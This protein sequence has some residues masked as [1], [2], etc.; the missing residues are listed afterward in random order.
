MNRKSRRLTVARP[1]VD[2]PLCSAIREVLAQHMFRTMLHIILVLLALGSTAHEAVAASQAFVV[3]T[4]SNT[5]TVI[6]RITNL[7]EATVT[8]GSLPVSVAVT[9]NEGWAYVANSGS[10]SVSVINV[11]P[12]GVS[13]FTVVATIRVGLTPVSIAITP[14]GTHAYVANARSN[15]VSVIDTAT[16]TVVVTVPVG[17]FPN[18]LSITPDGASVWVTNAGDHSV[19]IIDTSSN[20]V[21]A[22]PAVGMTPFDI[23]TP[24]AM[25]S[26]DLV[27]DDLETDVDCGGPVCPKCAQFKSCNV[28][29]DCQS[30]QCVSGRCQ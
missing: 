13:S 20:T 17:P 4:R 15:S 10:N 26:F 29:A 23:V 24:P 22:T 11:I 27:K 18:K 5:I 30:N 12:R 3:N 8:V 6:D 28:N 16:Q 19:S 7:V 9:P 25:C 21:T 1:K 2:N 14:D